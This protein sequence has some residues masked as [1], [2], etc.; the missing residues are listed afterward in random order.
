M[1]ANPV[2]VWSILLTLALGVAILFW[3]QDFDGIRSSWEYSRRIR[4]WERL[5]GA[6]FF[7]RYYYA[8]GIPEELVVALRKFHASYWEEDPELLRPGDDLLRISSGADLVDWAARMHARFGVM[9]P[10]SLP[11]ELRAVLP[12]VDQSI[13]CLVRCVHALLGRPLSWP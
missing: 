13:D 5:S 9:V 4:T 11:P 3:W 2:V 10:E 12:R 1:N 7:R 8:S 6:E